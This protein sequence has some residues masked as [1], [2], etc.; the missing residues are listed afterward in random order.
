MRLTDA[1]QD[2]LG[3]LLDVFRH[4]LLVDG[5]AAFEALLAEV[6]ALVDEPAR[7]AELPLDIRGTAFEER[8]WAEL[9]KIPVGTTAS[10]GE[11]AAALG[12]PT[13]HRAVARACGANRI[14]VIIPCHR[15]VRAD[16]SLSGYRWGVERK[17][18]LL[19]AERAA[20][21]EEAADA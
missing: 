2:G 17:R 1:A 14:A 8:V 3:S 5:G 7:A 19:D 20:R 13:A 6:I 9:R 16:G 12:H 21:V 11:I 18:A 4:A 10:Y 15:V